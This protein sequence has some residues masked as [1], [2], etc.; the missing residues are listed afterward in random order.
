MF[1]ATLLLLCGCETGVNP[2][3]GDS[4][5][6]T[7]WGYMD[8]SADTQKVRVFTVEQRIGLDRSGPIDA[9]VTS[10]DLDTGERR[11]W[12]DSLVAFPG[13]G[14]GHVFWSA[15][16]AQHGHR[17]RL[18]VKRSDGAASSVRVKVPSVADVQ[19]NPEAISYQLPVRI[20]GDVPNLVG[21]EVIYEGVPVY[22]ANPYPVGTKAP[23]SL[24]VPVHVSYAD[25]VTRDGPDWAF[26]ID[27]KEDFIAVASEYQRDCLPKLIVLARAK[28]RFLSA[29]SSWAPPDGD[30]DPDKLV[31]PTTFTNVENGYGFFGAGQTVSVSWVPPQSVQEMSGYATSVPCSTGPAPGCEIEFEPCFRC[32]EAL[33]PEIRALYC[34]VASKRSPGSS[35]LRARTPGF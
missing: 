14:N 8:A 16:R 4:K 21:L 2:Y 23:P 30:F 3:V 18:E 27:M 7:L 13:L 31:E 34:P 19:F 20:K 33:T 15:F 6:F 35:G 11:E 5:P 29:D 25:R 1:T 17:Y 32:S 28:L 22:P 24:V 12:K 10:V 9:H 26:R